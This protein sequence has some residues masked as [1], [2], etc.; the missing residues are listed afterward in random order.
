VIREGKGDRSFVA[1]FAQPQNLVGA[2]PHEFDAEVG[3]R[4]G[5]RIGIHLD[6]GAAIGSREGVSDALVTKWDGVLTADARPS[7]GEIRETELMFRAEVDYGAQPRGP[8]RIAGEA[9]AQA[10]QGTEFTDGSIELPVSGGVR[11]LMAEVDGSVVI[12]VFGGGTRLSRT[13]VPDA[14]PAGQFLEISESCGPVVPGGF[15]VRWGNPGQPTPL[16]HQYIV[17][18]DGRVKFVS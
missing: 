10:P 9:A 15:C 4:P 7:T 13:A 14:D 3:V 12:D 2:G 18:S 11:V 16:E 6:P 8:D 1:G 17:R 5:D